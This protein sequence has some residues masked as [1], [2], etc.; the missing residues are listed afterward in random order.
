MLANMQ[1]CLSEYPAAL[2]QARDRI[3]LKVGAQVLLVRNLSSR[4]GLVNGARGVV[5]KFQ[6][7]TMR[8]PVVRFANVSDLIPRLTLAMLLSCAVCCLGVDGFAQASSS[9]ALLLPRK[10]CGSRQHFSSS[11][12]C[13]L[14]AQ[15]HV[16]QLS[17]TCL[18]PVC[19]D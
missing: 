14:P 12:P 19:C 11:L 5:T 3:E 9:A 18:V 1:Q 8:L 7:S 10:N 13:L 15:L 16:M 17:Q 4:R 2:L 6:G